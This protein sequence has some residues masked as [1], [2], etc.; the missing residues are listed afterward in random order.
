MLGRNTIRRRQNRRS[1]QIH[2]S[3]TEKTIKPGVKVVIEK[4][5]YIVKPPQDT[6]PYKLTEVEGS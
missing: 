5:K 3:V 6:A 1:M 2:I 4:K